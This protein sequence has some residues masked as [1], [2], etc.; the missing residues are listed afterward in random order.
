RAMQEADLLIVVG[1]KLDYQTGYGSPA[2]LPNARVLR[3]GDNWEG[4]R[5]H[6]RGEVELSPAPG[7]PLDPPGKAIEAPSASLDKTWTK[8]LRDEHVRRAA[9]YAGSLAE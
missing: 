9:K 6:R 7:L 5:E 8:S 3:I 2:V 1:R 4:L